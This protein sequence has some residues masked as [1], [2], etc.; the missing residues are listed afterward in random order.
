MVV[1][2]IVQNT[3]SEAYTHKKQVGEDKSTNAHTQSQI[4]T[5]CPKKC[6]QEM[7][8]KRALM[9]PRVPNAKNSRNTTASYITENKSTTRARMQGQVK[10]AGLK[11][12][13]QFC[14]TPK[15]SP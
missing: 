13:F 7:L 6:S 10:N 14:D 9:H 1:G 3:H 15:P 2:L 4:T 12:N 11:C 8:P 5:S